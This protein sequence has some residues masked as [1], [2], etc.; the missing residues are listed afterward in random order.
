MLEKYLMKLSL[1]A[2]PAKIQ[3]AI[4]DCVTTDDKRDLLSLRNSLLLFRAIKKERHSEIFISLEAFDT[5]ESKYKHFLL[6]D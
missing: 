4:N 1:F 6:N 5:F 2:D 3:E